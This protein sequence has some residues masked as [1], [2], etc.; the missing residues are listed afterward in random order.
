MEPMRSALNVASLIGL[1]AAAGCSHVGVV[2]EI[3]TGVEQLSAPMQLQQTDCL[4]PPCGDA[5]DGVVLQNVRGSTLL[6]ELG[7]RWG[8]LFQLAPSLWLGL[9]ADLRT[10]VGS[11][12]P[13]GPY[14]WPFHAGDYRGQTG[15]GSF[16]MP[17]LMGSPLELRFDASRFYDVYGDVEPAWL[18]LNGPG[19]RDSA[20]QTSAF[21][22]GIQGDVLFRV[23]FERRLDFGRYGLGLCAETDASGL[24]RGVLVTLSYHQDED[25]PYTPLR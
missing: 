5:F 11:A 18:I 16:D 15:L 24:F 2:G 3:D 4:A 23:G 22:L 9:L 7:L 21:S 19:L 17:L 20:G 10:G 1:V 6:G 14:D 12:A 8:A 25:S 13:L